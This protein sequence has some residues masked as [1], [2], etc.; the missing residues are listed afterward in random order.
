MTPSLHLDLLKDEERF[1]SNPVRLR[2][3]LPML[4]LFAALG[5]AL[6]FGLCAFRMHNQLQLR[7]AV[8]QSIAELKTAH[9]ALLG[10]RVQ[11]SDSSAT[12]RQVRF[13]QTA[14]LVRFGETFAKLA[15][16]VPKNMQITEL[17]ILPP[18]PALIDPLRPALGPT[19][20]FEQV[21]LRLA[22][23]TA[24]EHASEAINTLIT[25]L[26]APAFTNLIRSVEI[27]KGAFRQDMDKGPENREALLFELTCGCS[28]RRFE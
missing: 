27:P 24:G 10:L 16:C 21:T 9:N 18:A 6:W 22:G 17:R 11:E 3:M 12:I 1:S 20:I 13:Y 23:R 15:P 8:E 19:N 25:S 7:R 2:V 4:F 28:P 26:R 14:C 5:M